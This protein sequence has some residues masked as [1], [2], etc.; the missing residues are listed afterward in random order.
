MQSEGI[1]IRPL[2]G[3]DSDSDFLNIR[4][5]N[6]VSAKNIRH[7]TRDGQSTFSIQDV[8][9]NEHVCTIPDAVEQG[10]QYEIYIDQTNLTTGTESYS[11]QFYSPNGSV[12]TTVTFDVDSAAIATS[13]ANFNT[14]FNAAMLALS[15]IATVSSGTYNAT[16]GYYIFTIDTL[17]SADFTIFVDAPNPASSIVKRYVLQ[18]A[19]SDEIVGLFRPIAFK[20]LNKDIFVLSTTQ[21]FEPTP[22]AVNIID[23]TNATP[24]VLEYS[25]PHNLQS[26]H[27]LKVTGV[28]GNTA[29]NG[30]FTVSYVNAT[31]VSLTFSAGNGAFIASPDAIS[32]NN[33]EGISQVGVIT[34]DDHNKTFAYFALLTTK[35]LGLVS[36]SMPDLKTEDNVTK[37]ALYWTE[38]SNVMRC[39]YYRGAYA[40][41]GAIFHPVNNL[42]GFYNYE[43]IALETQLLLSNVNIDARIKE[44]QQSGGNL[45]AG[46]IIYWIE[47]LTE[48]GTK[49][50]FIG[51]YG[52]VNIYK[53]PYTNIDSD[54][55]ARTILGDLEL[56]QT[57]KKV[58]LEISRI[59][60]AFQYLQVSYGVLSGNGNFLKSGTLPRVL[61]NERTT[62]DVIHSG[63]EDETEFIPGAVSVRT[64]NYFSAKNIDILDNRAIISNVKLAPTYDFAPWFATWKHSLKMYEMDSML[65][66]DALLPQ[67]LRIREYM[68]E[69]NVLNYRG[70]MLMER[71]RFYGVCEFYNGSQSDPFHI[72]DITFD[73]TPVAGRRTQTLPSLRLGGGA[74][75][76][77]NYINV[78]YIEFHSFDKEY[79]VDGLPISSIVKRVHIYRCEVG[80]KQV[81]GSGVIIPCISGILGSFFTPAYF[82]VSGNV[83]GYG[84]WPFFTTGNPPYLG[85]PDLDSFHIGHYTPQRRYG[86][87]YSYDATFNQNRWTV[88]PGDKILNLGQGILA[89][90]LKLGTIGGGED[91]FFMQHEDLYRV[92][93]PASQITVN[94]G[95]FIE[96]GQSDT[97]N[98]IYFKKLVVTDHDR[99]SGYVLHLASDLVQLRPAVI[100][101]AIYNAMYYRE[102]TANEQYGDIATSKCVPTGASY[103]IENATVSVL[104]DVFSLPGFFQVF[105]GD[106]FTHTGFLK[107]KSNPSYALTANLPGGNALLI[108]TTQSRINFSMRRLDDDGVTFPYPKYPQLIQFLQARLPDT[109]G[110][111][112][113]YSAEKAFEVM[114]LAANNPNADKKTEE[115]TIIAYSSKKQFGSQ[116]DGYR[117]F[118]PL[119]FAL[120]D[121][122]LGP[123]NAQAVANGRLFTW[124]TLMFK[125]HYFNSDGM[126][127]TEGGTEVVLG[128][129]KA[130]G[131]REVDISSYGCENK[132]SVIIGRSRGGNDTL[133]WINARYK[134]VIRFGADGTVA[135]NDVHTQ[136]FKFRDGITWAVLT[137][138]PVLFKGII[139]VWN[140]R[141]A[142]AFWHIIAQ[143]TVQGHG[144]FTPYDIGD[145]V[146]YIG[147]GY[148]GIIPLGEIYISKINGNLGNT[149]PAPGVSDVN[150]EWVPHT[151]TEYYSEFGIVFNEKNNSFTNIRSVTSGLLASWR[152]A[153]MMTRPIEAEK[154]QIYLDDEGADLTWYEGELE[155]EGYIEMVVNKY[156]DT[157]KNW[158]AIM[159]KSKVVPF[160]IEFRTETH[161]SFLVA[162]DFE[163][164]GN[165]YWSPIKMDATVTVDNP[166]GLNDIDT[167]I[168]C[169]RY[170]RIKMFFEVGVRQEMNH[171]VIKCQRQHRTVDQ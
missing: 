160:R 106:T 143:R 82:T 38:L 105:G 156:P 132:W 88:L 110:Y 98:S 120:M 161:Y 62:I 152:D 131:R 15:Y 59:P 151:N 79:V 66:Q 117:Y 32:Y 108:H 121:Y 40:N 135:I 80:N 78:P 100:D 85:Y 169:G 114:K 20:E 97:V 89:N 83:G 3:M 139:G 115:P 99:P 22:L 47:F 45:P 18:E 75:N 95:K 71:Y 84:D 70:Y 165:G 118:A 124:Q 92:N 53:A 104:P 129:G 140:H 8:M 52:P 28:L 109:T 168:L 37:K 14:A 73:D 50:D 164:I 122:S 57:P 101:Y 46:N 145:A 111:N 23:A 113:S 128:S 102:L 48:A 81:Q 9:G 94:E 138:N 148:A 27:K 72:D 170:L 6:Y 146:N 43:T 60:N 17:A 76:T 167:S 103:D 171:I 147:G 144:A 136:D 55:E 137:D 166:S 116:I 12:F 31:K 93:L 56:E 2:G 11:V 68:L 34:Y 10:K 44:V 16:S 19:W 162:A 7:I 149:P 130:L 87:F 90:V 35:S 69:S 157:D 29:A 42:T 65:S 51:P 123:I 158:Q 33:L 127:V 67:A 163:P 142:E 150:W 61:I 141:Y 41:D 36:A 112:K 25:G 49:T 96:H 119:D 126:F 30:V 64:P 54:T 133:Y 155:E 74:V 21:D 26:G 5:G 154:N 63:T 77:I 13:I 107:L 125:R 4:E 159:V 91:V 58:V 39:F 153:Y 134:K 24:I 1:R 86:C